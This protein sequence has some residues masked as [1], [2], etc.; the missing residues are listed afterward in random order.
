MR[1]GLLIRPW[2]ERAIAHPFEFVVLG[3]S[4]TALAVGRRVH[5]LGGHAVNVVTEDDVGIATRSRAW[6]DTHRA[7]RGPDAL[8]LLRRLGSDRDG[9]VKPFL[10]ATGD[11]DL[12]FVVAHRDELDARFDVLHPANDALVTC[13]DKAKFHR[14]CDAHGIP[15]PRW[16]VCRARPDEVR[17]EIAQAA[18]PMVARLT[19]RAPGHREFPKMFRLETRADI[20]TLVDLVARAGPS[21]DE[22]IVTESLLGCDLVRYSVAFC[23]SRRGSLT[24][25]A[26]KERPSAASGE[27]GTYVTLAD[28][29]AARALAQRA[30]EALDYHGLGEMEVFQDRG[31]D[32]YYAI[33]INARPWTQLGM[34]SIAGTDFLGFLAGRTSGVNG[35]PRPGAAWIDVVG[36]LYW[37]HSR[38]ARRSGAASGD[39]GYLR[40]LTRARAFKLFSPDDPGPVLAELA[41]WLRR[42]WRRGG[43]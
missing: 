19:S 39:R 3:S 7:A 21:D 17:R 31:A 23:R 9:S 28:A 2:V 14:F 22:L 32:R 36:D 20:E 27:V 16:R 5:E 15:V 4:S 6:A 1:R 40:S 10:L 26:R 29:P 11:D 12:W 43:S 41:E 25:E 42:T 34:E 30:A 35:R 13:L 24:F 8:Q 33:E 37:R 18:L 38:S